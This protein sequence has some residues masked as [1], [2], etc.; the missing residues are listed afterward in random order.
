M[1]I[2]EF[3]INVTSEQSKIIQE[4]LF[5]NDYTWASGDQ[6]FRYLDY[7]GCK[8]L[9]FSIWEE[10]NRNCLFIAYIE[11]CHDI[12]FEDF[13][14]RYLIKYFRREKLNKINIR[15]E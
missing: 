15:H 13:S 8:W 7:D 10:K 6:Y 4:F 11:N 2:E 14:Q 12:T 5:K 3:N 1:K 9:S